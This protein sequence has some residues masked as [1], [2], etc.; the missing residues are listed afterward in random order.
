MAN[1]K[2]SKRKGK[3]THT[4][5]GGCLSRVI[6]YFLWFG[7]TSAIL[8]ELF[9][10]EKQRGVAFD[11]L[12][13]FVLSLPFWIRPFCRLITKWVKSKIEKRKSCSQRPAI[14]IPT[15]KSAPVPALNDIPPVQ[16]TPDVIPVISH[17]EHLDSPVTV[18]TPTNVPGNLLSDP[19]SD[20]LLD[21]SSKVQA[22]MLTIDLMEGH[23]FEAWCAEAIKTIGFSDVSITPGSGDQGVDILATKDGVKY[24]IQCKRY[25][26]DLGNTPIQE[27]HSGKDFY[28]CHVGVVV[29]NQHFTDGARNLAQATGTLLWDREWI[30][31][32]LEHKY[33]C[34]TISSPQS[35][36]TKK[37]ETGDSDELFCAAVDIVLETG[38]ASV[39]LLQRRLKL[40]Y[41]R[42]ARIIDEMEERGI[43]GPFQG[44]APRVILITREQ[45]KHMLQTANRP[46]S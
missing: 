32:Y 21:K 28:R 12:L 42:A 29:T 31:H 15:K 13:I 46:F 37:E 23:R 14:N 38:Q 20:V 17:V 2:Y 40:G 45:W 27:V 9:P 5:N 25:N 39:S 19:F 7:F 22:E 44:S 33:S 43:V 8:I 34:E 30:K 4:S 35:A 3:Q 6:L 11:F 18:I 41:A 36:Q 1:N 26:T 24:A 16:T 10:D